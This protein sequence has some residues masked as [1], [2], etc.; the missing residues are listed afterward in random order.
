MKLK[1]LN[2]FLTLFIIAINCFSQPKSG[3]TYGFW[4]NAPARHWYDALV[5][6]N[7][8]MGVLVHGGPYNERIICNHEFLYEPVGGEEVNPPKIGKYLNRTRE[9]IL[10]GKYKDAVEYSYNNAKKEGYPG[11]LWTDPYHPAFAIT[12]NQPENGKVKNYRRELNFETGE[13]TVNW[14]DANGDWQRKTFV[15]R[16]DNVIV[17]QI[18]NLSGNKIN[19]TIGIEHQEGD[20]EGRTTNITGSKELLIKQPEINV[21]TDWMTF[22]LGYLKA[23]R[24][25]E[26]FVKVIA[27]DGKK[28]LTDNTIQVTNA[29]EVLLFTRINYLEE[30][31]KSRAIKTKQSINSLSGDYGTLIN[32]HAQIHSDMFLR[33]NVAFKTANNDDYPIEELFEKQEATPEKILPELLNKV[34]QMGKYV[35]ICSS[36]NNPP[37]LVGNWTGDWRPIWC[38]DF[39]LDANVNLQV[40][41]V[42]TLRL[43]ECLDSY[44]KMIERISPDWEINAENLYGCRGYLSGFRTSGRRNLHTHFDVSFPGQNWTAGAQWL[45]YPAFEYYLCTGDK[46]FLKN[47]ALP[48]MEK[49]VLFYED[50]LTVT[51]DE[52]Q[53]VFVPSYSPENT[54]ANQ[55]TGY[56]SCQAG[57]RKYY[58]RL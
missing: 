40:A 33:S 5:S 46:E 42:N 1:I 45:I 53:L 26:G 50:F 39:T 36:G 29:N 18:K 30:Y 16:A 15:S 48:L 38:G 57:F 2:S 47:R 52:G 14:T 8:E 17:Q 20:V 55:K 7:G 37:N 23:K 31:E 3:Y 49:V 41:G 56:R 54:P 21:N 34:Y 4:S 10:S 44:L 58:L 35:L 13:I 51:N 9:L 11:L 32:E 28:E 19:C 25:Y 27:K 12:I 6:G 22:R 43:E 24:G